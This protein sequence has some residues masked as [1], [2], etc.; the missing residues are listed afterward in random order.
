MNSDMLSN[1]GTPQLLDKTINGCVAS[2][3]KKHVDVLEEKKM[4][5]E[6][7]FI[8]DIDDT[9]KGYICGINFAIGLLKDSI[10]NLKKN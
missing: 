6:N 5:F 4:K 9:A 10:E 2:Y 3:L 1:N 7:R 8:F